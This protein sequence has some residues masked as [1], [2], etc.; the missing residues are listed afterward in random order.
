MMR[1]INGLCALVL[2][3]AFLLAAPVVRAQDCNG[4][5]V[6]D[7]TD[8]PTGSFRFAP[9]ATYP[10][11]TGFL[12]HAV[13]SGELDGTAG[14]DLALSTADEVVGTVAVSL[15]FNDGTGVFGPVVDHTLVPVPVDLVAVKLD[16]DADVDVALATRGVTD[17]IVV[18]LNDG[19]GTFVEGGT[20]PILG[21]RPLSIAAGDFDNDG[22][23]D[24]VTANRD[25]DD[26]S[27]LLNDG[28]ATFATAT[29]YAAGE[30]PIHVDAGD[31]DGDGYL[32]WAVA[33]KV[34]NDVSLL[35][36][37][38]DGTFAPAVSLAAGTPTTARTLIP[39]VSAM[40]ETRT[41]TTT[42]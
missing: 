13:A 4:N 3:S 18:L 31:I 37:Q 30:R 26:V 12:A 29:T 25:T 10:L 27:V 17:A 19:S 15:L 24:V 40:P 2:V 39:T 41:T 34:T 32:D 20:F 8:I 33:N 5:G 42:A 6:D 23:M 28:T 16:G 22:D 38:G 11:T 21:A 35:I 1:S 36:N 7:S 9:A 14:A